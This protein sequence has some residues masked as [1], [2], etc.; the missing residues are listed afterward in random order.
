MYQLAKKVFAGEDYV[1]PGRLQMYLQIPYSYARYILNRM[2]EEGFCEEQLGTW[3]CRVNK[4]I[5]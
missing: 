4:F 1:S 5:N 3:P 2:I